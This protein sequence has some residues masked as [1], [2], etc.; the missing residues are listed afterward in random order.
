MSLTVHFMKHLKEV[1][2]K[3]LTALTTRILK[4]YTINIYINFK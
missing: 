4:Y 3:I 1:E 2:M